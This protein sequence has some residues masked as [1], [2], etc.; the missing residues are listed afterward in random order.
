MKIRV[1]MALLPGERAI[2]MAVRPYGPEQQFKVTYITTD[3]D[4]DC[5]MIS[6]VANSIAE[7]L[8]VKAEDLSIPA[9]VTEKEDWTYEDEVAPYIAKALL[10]EKIPEQK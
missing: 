8:G 7:A 6:S 4:G 9:S 5:K 10:D 1:F 2:F 3:Y